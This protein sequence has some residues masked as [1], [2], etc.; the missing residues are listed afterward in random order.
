MEVANVI[1]LI[2][3][4]YQWLKISMLTDSINKSKKQSKKDIE[5]YETK[6]KNFNDKLAEFKKAYE[7]LIDED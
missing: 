4:F 1:L 2:V 7:Q 5:E 6:L 3:I